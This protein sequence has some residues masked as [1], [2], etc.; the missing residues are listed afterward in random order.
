MSNWGTR[1][2]AS[3]AARGSACTSRGRLP[4]PPLL[5]SHSGAACPWRSA[6]SSPIS[7]PCADRPSRSAAADLGSALHGATRRSMSI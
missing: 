2:S 4:R 5:P 6:A 1:S 7:P 3:P